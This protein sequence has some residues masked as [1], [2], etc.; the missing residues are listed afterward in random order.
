MYGYIINSAIKEKAKIVEKDEN[1]TNLRK[2]LNFGHTL[3]HAM[4]LNYD[5]LHGEAIA[6][7]MLQLIKKYD[8]YDEYLQIVKNLKLNTSFS[9]DKKLIYSALLNDKKCNENKIEVIEVE[10]LQ[11]PSICKM[12]ID[13]LLRRIE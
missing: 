6:L 5:L 3:G 8:Y 11:C 2:I 4:E 1:D 13:D 9:I 7:G 10:K 12:T